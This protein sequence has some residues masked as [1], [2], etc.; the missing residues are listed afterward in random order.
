[1]H[2]LST[3][4]SLS[5]SHTFWIGA[6][7]R[8]SPSIFKAMGTSC[9]RVKSRSAGPLIMSIGPAD[10][11]RC[12]YRMPAERYLSDNRPCRCSGVG[13]SMLDR[14]F[15]DFHVRPDDQEEIPFAGMVQ[16]PR[17]S[18]HDRALSGALP[19][20]RPDPR[21]AAVRQAADRHRADR[22]RPVA[23]QP[24]SP[25]ACQACPRGHRGSRR[26]A[27]R[28]SLPSDPGDRQAP[29]RRARPQPRLSQP[30]RGALRLS[31]RRRRA[32]HR[33]RQ[34]HARHF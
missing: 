33:L 17:Q 3:T 1:M 21:G 11:S 23:L 4:G 25:R 20:L 31:A 34:D 8:S 19:E 18:G 13:I 6:S 12:R 26:R 24:P 10:V 29:D 32:D 2:S 27:V 15:G 22:L 28:V 9:Q 30:G 5:A 14:I 7:M 16:Q